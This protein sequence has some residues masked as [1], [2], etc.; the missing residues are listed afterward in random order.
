MRDAIAAAAGAAIDAD[1]VTVSNGEDG[2]GGDGGSDSATGLPVD[3][4]AGPL[5]GASAE[6]VQPAAFAAVAQRYGA[7]LALHA[8]LLRWVWSPQPAGEALI[9][10]CRH[11]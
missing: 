11:W 8:Q 9:G 6:V 1:A 4:A 7:S 3:G 5:A 2:G 10:T